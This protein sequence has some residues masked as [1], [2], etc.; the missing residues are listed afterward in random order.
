MV[1]VMFTRLRRKGGLGVSAEV[2]T[3]AER[4]ALGPT[5]S[6]LAVHAE[7][8]VLPPGLLAAAARQLA[9]EALSR[10]LPDHVPWV[11]TEGPWTPALLKDL[12]H[13]RLRRCRL[14]RFDCEHLE[15]WLG[16]AGQD[17]EG[18]WILERERVLRSGRLYIMGR[19]HPTLGRRVSR[20]TSPE[21]I[22]KGNL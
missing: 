21:D 11:P 2:A 5:P 18:A 1:G 6:A 3:L 7:L 13:V 8:A 9:R 14:E 10:T 4:F 19:H 12:C 22:A 15:Y 17:A 16:T 20:K